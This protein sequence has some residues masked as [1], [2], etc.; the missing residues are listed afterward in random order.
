MC[1]R[2][3]A[4]IDANQE[5]LKRQALVSEWMSNLIL[6]TP[7]PILD[8][9]FAFSKIRSCES[10]YATKGGPMHEMCIRDRMYVIKPNTTGS[11]S[12][13]YMVDYKG[14]TTYTNGV[15][16][17]FTY[18]VY[19]KT[20]DI[21]T[22]QYPLSNLQ[23]A[24]TVSYTHLDVYKRQIRHSSISCVTLLRSYLFSLYRSF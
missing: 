5:L 19:C 4:V 2:D 1:I 7:D 18:E 8:K 11:I 20:S 23:S 16:N 3:R 9:M 12:N 13:Y 17:G 6:E 21:K 24:G 14:N 22:M 15:K 10:I